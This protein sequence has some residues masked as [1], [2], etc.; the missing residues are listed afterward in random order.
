[1]TLDLS[2]LTDDLATA[3]RMHLEWG[4][5]F[6]TVLRAGLDELKDELGQQY[7][8]REILEQMAEALDMKYKTLYNKLLLSRKPWAGLAQELSLELGH[9]DA[10][11]GLED[12]QA[13]DMLHRAA[14]QRWTVSELRREVYMSKIEEVL[15]VDGT[16]EEPPFANMAFYGDTPLGVR[17]YD[18]SRQPLEEQIAKV[19]NM[20]P[21]DERPQLEKLLIMVRADERERVE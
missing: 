12:E 11:S 19:R 20:L 6:A 10:V 14:E 3:W 21:P 18:Y 8:E 4:W 9:G 7:N 15:P 17:P 16:D 2:T 1:M 5:R 13:E